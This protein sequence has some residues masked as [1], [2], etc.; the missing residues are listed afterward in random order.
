[1][2]V[3]FLAEYPQFIETIAGWVF[4]EW[5]RLRPGM[6]L[7]NA[8]ADFRQR[9]VKNQIPLSLIAIEGTEVI[10]CI[11]LKS[12]EDITRPGLT[13]WIGGAYVREDWRGK[14]V[15][16][17]MITAVENLAYNLGYDELYLSAA[18]A[19]G[20][21]SGLGWQV[22]ERVQAEGEDVAVMVRKLEE[23]DA[24]KSAAA[25]LE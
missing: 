6:T 24:G 25:P 7:E 20:F 4:A 10:G 21:Y 17:A 8:I 19:E 3:D 9:A 18:G 1:M 22:F 12:E 11:S 14:G 16:E 15:G 23:G 13:P 2:K 5:G